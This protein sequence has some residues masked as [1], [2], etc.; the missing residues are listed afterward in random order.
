MENFKVNIIVDKLAMDTKICVSCCC[1]SNT[2]NKQ[3]VECS[4][5]A[6]I[7]CIFKE[8]VIFYLVKNLYF[9]VMERHNE[10]MYFHLA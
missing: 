6:V 8:L 9:L 1:H 4:F 7:N 5:I 10:G 3:F 2:L